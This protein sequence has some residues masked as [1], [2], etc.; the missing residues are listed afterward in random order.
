[1]T[2]KRRFAVR[3]RDMVL[4]QACRSMN[5]KNAHCEL[6]ATNAGKVLT[7]VHPLPD[8]CLFTIVATE[9]NHSRGNTLPHD[10]FLFGRY[11]EDGGRTWGDPVYSIRGPR[12]RWLCCTAVPWWTAGA[13]CTCSHCGSGSAALRRIALRV[14]SATSV[15]LFLSK[16]SLLESG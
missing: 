12:S 10:Q 8:G 16:K 4:F 13:I 11:S 7:W 9:K 15:Q 3:D 5:E 14:G 6:L 2:V 1:V